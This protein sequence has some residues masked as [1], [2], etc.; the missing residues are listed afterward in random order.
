MIDDVKKLDK[1]LSI[2]A[3]YGVTEITWGGV[4]CKLGPIPLTSE[5]IKELN[6]PDLTDEQMAFLA[7][8]GV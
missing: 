4:S 1:F 7:V 6:T 2:C 5:E 3:K 8:D